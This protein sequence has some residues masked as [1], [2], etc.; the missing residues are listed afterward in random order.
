MHLHTCASNLSFLKAM[1]LPHNAAS[2]YQLA[3]GTTILMSAA[4]NPKKL[5]AA[6]SPSVVSSLVTFAAGR[7]VTA[8]IV[9]IPWLVAFTA[10]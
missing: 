4:R 1:S 2:N 10:V 5:V 3:I 8:I 6:S 9:I 7:V